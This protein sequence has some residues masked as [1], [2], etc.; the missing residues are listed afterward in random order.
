MGKQY[1][2]KCPQVLNN[3]KAFFKDPFWKPVPNMP[4]QL[5]VSEYDL[6]EQND[7]GW[8]LHIVN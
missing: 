7:G 4:E 2:T 3:H 6:L 8:R 1:D 5:K